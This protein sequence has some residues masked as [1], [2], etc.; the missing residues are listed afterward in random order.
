[1]TVRF[2]AV[3]FDYDGVL[4]D[5]LPVHVRSWQH[6]FA[7]YGVDVEALEVMLNEGEKA[8]KTAKK[9]ADKR[10]LKLSEEEFR[11]LLREK[12]DYYR[13]HAPE[14]LLP[15]AVDL[16]KQI[17]QRGLRLALVTGSIMK[18]LER[19]MSQDEKSLFDCIITS[20]TVDNSKPHPEP[21]LRAAQELGLSPGECLVLENAP[22]G[23]KAAR[24]AGMSVAAITTTLPREYLKEAD[25]VLEEYKQLTEII[26]G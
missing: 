16:L 23:I 24:S 25:W 19:V 1:M 7:R 12:R 4:V 26:G 9:I 18:N 22:L 11:I 3:L 17:K 21:F 13:L 8:L 2:R 14:G 6:A 20:E 5:S 10:G 15:E